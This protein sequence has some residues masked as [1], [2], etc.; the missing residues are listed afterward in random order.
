MPQLSHGAVLL[1]AFLLA[2]CVTAPPSGP[3]V[4]VL[5]AKDK[6]FAQFQQEDANCRQF[7]SAQTGG[8]SPAD[9]ANN[10]T[11]TSAALGTVLG[12]AAGAAI[13]AAAGNPAAGA[14]IGAG[15][16]LFLGGASGLNAGAYSAT[17]LQ[18]RYD[19]SYL[20]C[21]AASGNEVPARATPATTR[22]TATL[23]PIPIIP[24]PMPIP[25]IIR[26]SGVPALAPASSFSAADI[27]TMAASTTTAERAEPAS[28]GRL[29]STSG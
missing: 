19:M 1:A 10:S 23:I 27:T 22:L 15:S 29:G 26:G 16:G 5:P 12:A 8:V 7:A 21:M 2:G 18:Q 6:P 17:S 24:T 9:A 3:S 13:G 4:L 11:A 14:A 20:Q 28:L 25:A